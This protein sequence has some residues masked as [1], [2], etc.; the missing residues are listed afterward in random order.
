[1]G[2]RTVGFLLLFI[3]SL[4]PRI[5]PGKKAAWKAGKQSGAKSKSIWKSPEK[6]IV[7]SDTEEQETVMTSA[8]RSLKS[9]A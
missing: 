4:F 9:R 1:L 7:H 5:Y 3:Q 8:V 2:D 6:A